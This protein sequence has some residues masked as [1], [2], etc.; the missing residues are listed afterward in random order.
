MFTNKHTESTFNT[1]SQSIDKV[2]LINET[3]HKECRD[4]FW[5]LAFML[6]I[7]TN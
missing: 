5:L 7:I 6:V 3:E 4:F 2:R 1:T